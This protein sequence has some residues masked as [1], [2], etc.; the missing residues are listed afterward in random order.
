M[1]KSE[2]IYE[3]I[4]KAARPIT[5]QEIRDIIKVE[6]PQFCGT[7]TNL[8]GEP[9]PSRRSSSASGSGRTGYSPFTTATAL[10]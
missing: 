8:K 6:Y 9:C 3:T 1:K 10:I 4:R 7:E 5:P 2:A